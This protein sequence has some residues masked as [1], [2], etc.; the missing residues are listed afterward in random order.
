MFG[1]LRTLLNGV[2]VIV[3]LLVIAFESPLAALLA[4]ILIAMLLDALNSV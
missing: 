3:G 2:A 1:I 4:A